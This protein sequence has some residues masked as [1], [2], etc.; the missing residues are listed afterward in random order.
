MN[1][2][3]WKSPEMPA[4]VIE[5]PR[6]DSVDSYGEGLEKALLNRLSIRHTSRTTP[7]GE[8]DRVDQFRSFH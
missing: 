8:P 4:M 3:S 7:E 5:R 1:A 2:L 6:N